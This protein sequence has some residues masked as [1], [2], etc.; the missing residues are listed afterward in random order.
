[1]IFI[2]SFV[3]TKI[4]RLYGEIKV[5]IAGSLILTLLLAL[6]P[7]MSLS[8]TYTIFIFI[9][10]SIAIANSMIPIYLSKYFGHLGQGKVMGLQVS[11]FCITNV[12]IAIIGGPLTILNSKV[13]LLLGA[14]FIGSSSLLMFYHRN[15]QN[16]M[17]KLKNQSSCP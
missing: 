7:F 3:V 13:I 2:S 14:L 4:N 17:I 16:Q 6:Q 15:G 9:G 8:Q 12:I 1:M 5:M 10:G 11:I